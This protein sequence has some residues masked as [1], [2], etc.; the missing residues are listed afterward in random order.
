MVTGFSFCSKPDLSTI[1]VHGPNRDRVERTGAE[2][3]T[4]TLQSNAYYATTHFLDEL[5]SWDREFGE[6]RGFCGETVVL[7]AKPDVAFALAEDG[8]YHHGLGRACGG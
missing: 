5:V 6:E 3:G 2:I 8:A 1:A 7:D 4:V